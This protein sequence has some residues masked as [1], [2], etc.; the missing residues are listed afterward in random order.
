M[1]PPRNGR[2]P[3]AGPPI[4]FGRSVDEHA[5]RIGG[6]HGTRRRAVPLPFGL[7]ESKLERPEARPGITTRS[8]LLATIDAAGPVPV[9]AVVAPAGYGKSTLLAQWAAA[10][11]PDSGWVS[12]DEGDNDPA[13]LM[14]CL[15]AVLARLGA[16]DQHLVAPLAQGAG[17]T[18]RPGTH[19]RHPGRRT[20]GGR[21]ARPVRG[22]HQPG[23]PLH[24]DGGRP[25][26]AARLADR[27]R[28]AARPAPAPPPA[29]AAG[30]CARTRRGRA[31]DVRRRGPP[32]AARYGRRTRRRRPRP[33][34]RQ[35]RGLA[36]RP[37][38]RRD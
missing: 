2:C 18:A 1:H 27:D 12:C 38:P 31:R 29:A 6:G 34:A 11:D 30:R 14:T 9:V 15:A 37:L 13:V 17:I 33:S 8:R 36:R 28:L 20:A 22:D 23:V 25:A 4:R 24:P 5:G 19:G 26:A 16:I 21:R 35:H 32:A 3:T 10:K 7:P